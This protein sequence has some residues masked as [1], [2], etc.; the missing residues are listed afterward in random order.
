M[1]HPQYTQPCALTQLR[2]PPPFHPDQLHHAQQGCPDCLDHLV[3]QNEPLVHWVLR[4]FS[5]GDLPYD[6]ALQSGRIGLWQALRSFDPRRDTAFSTYAVVA[7]RR[8]VQ[9]EARRCRR[10]GPAPTPRPTPPP[11]PLDEL[12]R[13]LLVPVVRRWVA[14]LTPRRAAVLRA[15]Y[16]LDGAPPQLQRTIAQALGVTRQRVQQLLQEARLLLALPL[17]SWEVRLL[18]ERTAR[19]DV[20]A[21]QQAWYRFCR[22]RR[23]R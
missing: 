11:D 16:G 23:S 10:F 4:H 3:R 13:R 20:R 8:H 22:Q 1:A 14:H 18:T 15:Y 19:Q 9:R 7:I 12:Q 17:Y 6:E 5:P 21:A 2:H